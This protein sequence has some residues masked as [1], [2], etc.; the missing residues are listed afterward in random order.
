MISFFLLWTFCF[1]P[2]EPEWDGAKFTNKNVQAEGSFIVNTLI[3]LSAS[4]EGTSEITYQWY[5]NGEKIEGNTN[6]SGTDSKSLQ[7][8]KLSLADVGNYVC[9]ASNN[10]GE[11]STS[12][13]A[14]KVKTYPVISDIEDQTIF[15]TGTFTN[16]NLN[17]HVSDADN[18]AE[19]ISWT[20]STTKNLTIA[21]NNSNLASITVKDTDWVGSETV[22]FTAED[23]DDLKDTNYVTF[24][25][26]SSGTAPVVS[27]IPDQSISQGGSFAVINLD[28]FVTDK[29][30]ADDQIEW[31]SSSTTN[32]TVLIKERKATITVKSTT[33]IGEETVTFTASDPVGLSG[34]D[35]AKF[36]VKSGTNDKP[37]IVSDIPGQTV[38][39]GVAFATINLDDY[40]TDADNSVDE[41][42]WKNSST[43][44][45]SVSISANRIAT[46][47][48][49]NADW[50]GSET[51]KFTVTD[52]TNLSSTDSAVFTVTDNDPPTV[53][54]IPDDSTDEG[55]SFT[56]INL[57]DYVSDADNSDDE[58]TW[59]NST[60]TN[61]TVTISGDRKA[62][63]TVKDADWNGDET[64]TFTATDPTGLSNSN[65]ANYKVKPVNDAPVVDDIP[66]E[67]IKEDSTFSVVNLDD[68]VSDIDNQKDEIEWTSSVTINLTITFS[69]DRKATIIVKDPEWNGSENVVFTATDPDGL[70]D[71]NHAVFTVVGEGD[72]P[73]VSNIPNDSIDEGGSF[74]VINLDDFVSD[75]DNSDEE[76]AW[77]YSTPTYFDVV[78]S[79]D[80][81]A[82]ITVKDPEWNGDEDITFTATDPT[83]LSNSDVVNF[84]VNPVNDL[85]VVTMKN[86]NGVNI[87][88]NSTIQ[89]KEGLPL[90]CTVSVTDIDGTAE[91]LP[92]LNA[93]FDIAGMG[94]GDYNTQTG[95]FTYTPSFAVSD[96]DQNG[97]FENVDFR[98]QDDANAT[99]SFKINIEVIDSNSAPKWDPTTDTKNIKEDEPFSYKFKNN[100]KGDDEGD[101]VTFKASFGAFNSDTTEWTWTP[102][103]ADTG[104]QTLK[105]TATDNHNPAASSDFT[106]VLN[107]GS[108]PRYS[109][110]VTTE[111]EG[112]VDPAVGLF[113]EGAQVSITP[114][115]DEGWSF[116]EWTGDATGSDNPL[117]L[118]MNADKNIKAVFEIKKYD[119]NT[120]ATNGSITKD[121]NKQSYAHGETVTVKAVPNDGYGFSGWSGDLSGANNPH[122][123]TMNGEKSIEAN[124]DAKT[125]SVTLNKQDGN[126]GT[127][128]VTVTYGSAMPSATAPNKTGYTFNGYYDAISGGTQYYTSDMTSARNWDK[129][130]SDPTLY[131]RWTVK[132]Y[133]VTLD[134]QNGTGGSNSVTVTYGEPMPS[135]SAPSRTGYSFNGYFD[136]SSGGTQYYT[137]GMVSARNWDKTSNNPTLYAQWTINE[138]RI[139]FNS[140]G[141]SNV[142]YD[143]VPY[144][145]L[146]PEPTEP[147]KPGNNFRGWYKESSCINPWDFASERV[148]ENRTLYA[149][150]EV[151]QYTV[152]FNSMGGDGVSSQT[153]DHNGLVNEPSDPD[154]NNYEFV[155]WYKERDC[156]NR[157]FFGSDRVTSNITLYA[158][159]QGEAHTVTFYSNG[160]SGS[161]PTQTIRYG[162]TSPLNA[163]GF[164]KQGYTLW[165]WAES[166]SGDSTYG[167]QVNFTM[168]TNDVKLYAIW[169]I[170]DADRN[171]YTAVIINGVTWLKENLKTTKYNDGTPIP[172]VTSNS[173]W[174][175]Q[176]NGAYCWYSNS[177]GN[178]NTYGALYNWP[179]VNTGK[180]APKGWHVATDMDYRELASYCDPN[181]PGGPME[182][183]TAAFALKETGN[184]YWTGNHP[185][186]N[187][188]TGFSARGAGYRDGS[189]GSFVDLRLV[190]FLWSSAGMSATDARAYQMVAHDTWLYEADYR[191][192]IDGHSV[193][194]VFGPP[195]DKQ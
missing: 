47:T 128:S 102:T 131:A 160:A 72:P 31:T 30:H 136:A 187:N 129:T 64:I 67:T 150:W 118:T 66:N 130:S 61:L 10:W 180:L 193:R 40:V 171:Q 185:S 192:K 172:N 167:D 195:S 97:K 138:Y 8:K 154:K 103:V 86:S 45:L 173:A 56:V 188:R 190:S 184:T 186:S 1:N 11:D 98:G 73:I 6:V 51:I 147:D 43:T 137:S 114:T 156:I 27:D 179:A 161:T 80:R 105:I 158:K 77:T 126:G 142:P 70:N 175:N 16:I 62:T 78:I 20:A 28:E 37:P 63:I 120:T 145:Q 13:Y 19:E 12:Q 107:V 68:F 52:P 178:K 9:K 34:S 100:F 54:D 122:T 132:T 5:K 38:K 112:S 146:L 99:V 79:G 108:I 85:P 83:T 149:K 155:N 110:N 75:A 151:I 95:V 140:M 163:C 177:S 159:W 50:T 17:N 139:T 133:T 141:G 2:V 76:I 189:D 162:E 58:I 166:A 4:A 169:R 181:W 15:Q 48:A 89:I 124:F 101:D 111:G 113:L 168:G 148:T 81:K 182:Y 26:D 25:V 144:N 116:K 46:I 23:P 92:V 55:G 157:W 115:P 106:L 119:L 164:S 33:W 174:G 194:C 42:T 109:L 32:L 170:M 22:L 59:T 91:L 7:I 39:K 183:D 36:T 49:H 125:Y 71:T 35:F 41:L 57:D 143:D 84:K 96:G 152:N 165:G 117:S 153:V 69:A 94:S 93:P 87:S 134:R 121:P 53:A 90:V 60:P 3:K 88:A 176:T 135:A 44:Y 104:V 191:S 82:T 74:K 14:L 21:I 127:N 18:S 29:E 123:I 24:T 65:D